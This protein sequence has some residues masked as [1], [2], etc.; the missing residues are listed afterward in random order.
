MLD[1]QCAFA[2]G[3]KSNVDEKAEFDIVTKKF[4]ASKAA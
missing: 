3:N 1:P 2:G 4:R